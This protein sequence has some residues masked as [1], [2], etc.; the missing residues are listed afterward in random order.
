LISKI[1]ADSLI[2]CE[3]GVSDEQI[4]ALQKFKDKFEKFDSSKP[5]YKE[6]VEIDL[7]SYDIKTESDK[8]YSVQLTNAE[9]AM[10]AQI[11]D[12]SETMNKEQQQQNY[13]NSKGAVNLF[14]FDVSKMSSGQQA[15]YMVLIYIAIAT[16][17]YWFYT[18]LVKNKEDEEA[19]KQALKDAKK[20]KREAKK[21]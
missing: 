12:I 15:L 11:E 8:G 4:V 20:A 18:I 2:K 10:L 3:K 14:F 16:A 6:L 1:Q 5:G 7:Q 19:H 17:A 21:N 13:K 9:N